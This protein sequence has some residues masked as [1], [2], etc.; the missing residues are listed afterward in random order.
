L[1]L[2][3]P[4]V[5]RLALG[6]L[7]IVATPRALGTMTRVDVPLLV[8]VTGPP[9]SGKTTIA[10]ALAAELG[11]PLLTKDDVKDILFDALGWSDREWS[12]NVG[13]AS[14]DVLFLIVERQLAAGLPMIAE[15]N[16]RNSEDAPRFRALPPHRLVQIH[17][18]A[19]REILLTRY[20]ERSK[21]PGHLG[22]TVVPEIAIGLD[23][24]EWMPL[25]LEGEL[26]ELDTSQELDAA[27]VIRRMLPHVERT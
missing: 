1:E 20:G 18:T 11:L 4:A 26:I 15:S 27:E 13:A 22:S 19:P 12:R 24:G 9:A 10:R 23:V 2:E 6:H 17:L 16:F 14:L 21:H 3:P 25:Q 8:V 5:R 7:P